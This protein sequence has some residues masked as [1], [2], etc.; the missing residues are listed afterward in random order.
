MFRSRIWGFNFEADIVLG[1]DFVQSPTNITI[2]LCIV[3]REKKTLCTTS[4]VSKRVDID[5]ET[6]V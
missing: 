6:T 5:S 2:F 4:S 1:T 3:C